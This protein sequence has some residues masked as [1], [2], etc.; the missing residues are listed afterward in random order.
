MR[1][2]TSH[3]VDGAGVQPNLT[4]LDLPSPIHGA[5]HWYKLSVNGV[6]TRIHFQEGT[7]PVAGPNGVSIE[8]LLAICADRLAGFQSGKFPCEENA[9]ALQHI[10]FAMNI[11]KKRTQGRINRNVE[12]KLCD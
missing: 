10:E 2:I 4:V 12:G 7:M 1:E 9:I 6:D 8:S 11:L 5:C 3:L